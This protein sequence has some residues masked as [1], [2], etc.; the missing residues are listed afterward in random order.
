MESTEATPRIEPVRKS[1]VVAA[2]VERA[3]AV[4]TERIGE[5]WPL[6]T[7][8]VRAE[9]AETAVLEPRLGGAIYETWREGR[10]T[11]GEIVVWEPPDRLVFTWSPVAEPTEVEVRFTPQGDSTLVELEHRGWEARGAKAATI[12]DSY[13]EGWETVLGLYAGAATGARTGT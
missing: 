10:E 9:L 5:W 7:H 2:P 1:V 8:S 4:F 13:D 3:F 12:R 6:K 11:W